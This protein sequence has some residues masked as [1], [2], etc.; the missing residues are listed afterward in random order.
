MAETV[1]EINEHCKNAM[2]QDGSCGMRELI[3]W[4]QS[5]MIVKDELESAKYTILSAVSA[6]AENR[7]DVYDSCIAPKYDIA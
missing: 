2:I 7:A 6:D 3:S 1:N 5:Y 4:V